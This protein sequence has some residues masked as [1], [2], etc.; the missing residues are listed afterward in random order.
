MRYNVD[1]LAKS[2]ISF[3]VGLKR[4][5]AVLYVLPNRRFRHYA[6]YI[7]LFPESICEGNSTFCETV[8]VDTFTFLG[9][10]MDRQTG[11]SRGRY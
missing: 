2:M 6:L 9:D 7:E 10:S 5:F 3:V 1:G 4:R 11:E 8:N